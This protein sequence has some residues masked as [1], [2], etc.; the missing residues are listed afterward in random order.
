MTSSAIYIAGKNNQILSHIKKNNVLPVS[1]VEREVIIEDTSRIA[2]SA[3]IFKVPALQMAIYN[4]L[5]SAIEFVDWR[6][7]SKHLLAIPQTY[8]LQKDDIEWEGYT[9]L[10][11]FEMINWIDS[12][13][14]VRKNWESFT[15]YWLNIE[16]QSEVPAMLRQWYISHLSPYP[17]ATIQL[18][19]VPLFKSAVDCIN[20]REVAE[21]IN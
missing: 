7:L 17:G 6:Y 8:N 21:E 20:W 19:S 5:E 15:E 12:N 14:S 2:E 9:N 16:P 13:P 11:T 4:C 3:D 18:E 1:T 10:L